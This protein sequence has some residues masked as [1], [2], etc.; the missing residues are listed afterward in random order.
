MTKIKEIIESDGQHLPLVNCCSLGVITFTRREWSDH[1]VRITDLSEN[2]VWI[3]SSH[4]IEPGFV[5]FH[6]RVRGHKGG[7]LIWCREQGEKYRGVIQFVPLTR[8]EERTVQER[9]LRTSGHRPNRSPEEIIAVLV[10]SMER[11]LH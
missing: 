10:E 7:L 4:P 5:W 11:K 3:E 1:T 2:G 9:T 6:D 8:D